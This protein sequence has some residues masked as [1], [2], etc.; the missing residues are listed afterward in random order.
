MIEIIFMCCYCNAEERVKNDILPENWVR[1]D[2][3]D[4]SIGK[5]DEKGTRF[6][7]DLPIKNKDLHF[8][9]GE[10]LAGYIRSE[11]SDF[12]GGNFGKRITPS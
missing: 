5:K 9:S 12:L 2:E 11:T 8:C 7:G 6:N 1:V 4:L 3:I 10:C